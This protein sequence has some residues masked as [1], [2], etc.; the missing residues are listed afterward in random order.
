MSVD[1]K[2]KKSDLSITVLLVVGILIVVNF[3]SYQIFHR[4]D[5]TENKMYSISSVSRES[6]KN[7]DDIVNV[8]AYFSDNLPG[9][10]LSVKQE[11]VDVLDE[12]ANYSGG[13]VRVEYVNPGTDESAMREVQMKGIAPLTFQV[14]EKDKVEM[15]NGYMGMIIEYGNRSEVIA[16][17]KEDTSDLEYQITSAIK[18]VVNAEPVEIGLLT[19]HGTADKEAIKAAYEKLSEIYSVRDIDL[20]AKD[21]D[22]GGLDSLIVI[23]PK[24]KFTE[25]EL[26]KLDKFLSLGGDVIALM[27]GVTVNAEQGLAAD[28]NPSNFGEFLKKN[29]VTVNNDLILDT[30]SGT[31]SFTQNNF[32]FPLSVKY[33]FWPEITKEGFNQNYSAV[34]NL[35]NIVLP[36]V[37]SVSIDTAKL[38]QDN[39]SLLISSS[40]GSWR[41][42][43]N[44]DLNPNA[45]FS[46]S[47]Q[48]KYDLAVVTNTKGGDQKKGRL[49]VIGDS[50]FIFDGFL[51]N[52]PSNLTFFQNLVDSLG[53][54]EDLINIR[55]KTATSRP[56]NDG[57]DFSDAQRNWIRF[58]NV[59]G[60]TILTVTFGMGRYYFRRKASFADEL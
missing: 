2:I 31:I 35:G 57:K 28:K 42:Q 45:K 38:G 52:N 55:A 6:V 39:F 18:K 40:A 21:V 56:L 50:E 20:A 60:I 16:A 9:Q 23:G 58:L 33:P 7:L 27:D 53:L 44:F 8:K 24:E 54:G 59:F 43:D 10:I 17:F 49:A 13:H 25:E 26:G 19:S 34:A 1:K 11:I 48:K 14:V 15:V 37:S 22:L 51:R 29:G 12:Y 47:E 46:P 30:R 4:W 32:P 41:M 3:F 36:W 5:L